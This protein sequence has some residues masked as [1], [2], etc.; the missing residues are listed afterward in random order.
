VRQVGPALEGALERL[1]QAA[2]AAIRDELL[3]LVARLEALLQQLE[4]R[5]QAQPAEGAKLP[6]PW[7]RASAYDALNL[8]NV[9]FEQLAMLQ[10]D[11]GQEPSPEQLRGQAAN[12]ARMV[13]VVGEVAVGSDLHLF[14]ATKRLGMAQQLAGAGSA[15][16][17]AAGAE[18]ARALELRYGASSGDEARKALLRASTEALQ[19]VVV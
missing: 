3:A 8:A 7:V 14:V 17:A 5:Q 16:A 1:D 10:Q 2:M 4:Q 13:A 18:V 12:L 19:R 11:A 15:E 6:L 9:C